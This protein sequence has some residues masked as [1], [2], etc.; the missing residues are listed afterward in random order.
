MERFVSFAG[1]VMMIG[2]AWLLSEHNRRFP[3]RVVIVGTV[4]QLGLR[5]MLGGTI[6]NCMTGSVV[7]VLV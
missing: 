5:A 6:V 3:G 2:L 4:L 7:G 1:Y